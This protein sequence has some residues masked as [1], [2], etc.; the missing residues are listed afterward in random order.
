MVAATGFQIKGYEK[1]ELITLFKNTLKA[2]S[3]LFEFTLSSLRSSKYIFN[4]GGNVTEVLKDKTFR[5]FYDNR[6]IIEPTDF[7]YAKNHDISNILLDN[8]PLNNINQ[9]KTFRFLSKFPIS[10]PYNKNNANRS[11]TLYRSKLELGLR[12]FIKAYYSKNEKLGLRGNEFKHIKDIISF[13]SGNR[14]TND[15]KISISSVS[16]LKNRRLIWKPVPPTNENLALC[17][18]IKKYTT[19]SLEKIYS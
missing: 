16:K 9:C 2:P 14:S 18:Y 3:K 12:N 15:I 7:N 8:E 10:L 1:S 19:Q 13:I 6:R 4:K 11:T 5:L 17:K